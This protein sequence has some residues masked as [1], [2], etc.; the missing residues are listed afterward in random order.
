MANYVRLAH[1]VERS[2]LVD[3]DILR[4]LRKRATNVERVGK[5]CN[6]V[7]S[8]G[9]RFY[10]EGRSPTL[11]FAYGNALEG[12]KEIRCLRDIRNRERPYSPYTGMSPAL[13]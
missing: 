4:S 6:I 9:Q 1:L 11:T 8:L 3:K 5:N 13:R 2:G 7:H 12:P 10:L